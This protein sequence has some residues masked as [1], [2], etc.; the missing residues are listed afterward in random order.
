MAECD[1]YGVRLTPQMYHSGVIAILERTH[2]M[3]KEDT[4]LSINKKYKK[5]NILIGGKFKSTLMMNKLMA[6][7]LAK[8]DMDDIS[9][10]DNMYVQRISS[11]ELRRYMD[12]KGGSFYRHLEEAAEG[13]T[14]KTIGYSDPEQKIFD[15]LAVIIRARYEDGVLTIKYNPDIKDYLINI[16]SN[17]T[18][19]NLEQTMRFKKSN[20]AFRLYELLRSEC[21]YRR[22]EEKVPGKVFTAEYGLSELKFTIGLIDASEKKVKDILRGHN[23]DYEA[24]EAVAKDGVYRD[25]ASFKKRVL[26]PA[27]DEINEVTDITVS[28]E[29]LRKSHGKVCGVL[30]KMIFKEQKDSQGDDPA[31]LDKDVIIDAVSDMI[32]PPLRTKDIRAICEAANY[33]LAKIRNAYDYLEGYQNPVE[34]VPGFLIECIK[35]DYMKTSRE[36]IPNIVRMSADKKRVDRIEHADIRF[37]EDIPVKLHRA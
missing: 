14:G 6:I 24:A 34:N 15:Y 26:V 19:L 28:Y 22:G 20:N 13:M 33:D 27:I 31:T 4:S 29:P 9:L 25:W 3:V 1:K 10:E 11:A 8:L 35:N 17:Y 18:V 36:P 37:D 21:Y 12:I 32:D 5:S 23:P 7:S 2:Q 30:F 16:K